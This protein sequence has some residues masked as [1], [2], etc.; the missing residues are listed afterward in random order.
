MNTFYNTT[1]IKGEEFIKSQE[2]ALSQTQLIFNHLAI[3]TEFSAWTIHSSG[4]LHHNTPITSIRRALNTLEKQGKIERV[5]RVI[6][7]LGKPEF[8]Y[9]LIL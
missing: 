6:G 4:I 2:K 1:N 3:N 7:L 9:K 5:G 8:T